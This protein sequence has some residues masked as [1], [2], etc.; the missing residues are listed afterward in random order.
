MAKVSSVAQIEKAQTEA[1]DIKAKT[2]MQDERKDD[3]TKG[4][5]EIKDANQASQPQIQQLS[6]D[7]FSLTK[8]AFGKS[9]HNRALDY[10]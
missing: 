9:F 3:L 6:E 1:A 4:S 5:E 8:T 2:P 10:S 7:G